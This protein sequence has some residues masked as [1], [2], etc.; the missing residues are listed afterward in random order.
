VNTSQSVFDKN[1]FQQ[2]A[3]DRVQTVFKAEAE[4]EQ[5]IADLNKALKHKVKVREQELREEQLS[6]RSYSKKKLE[7]ERWVEKE[8]REIKK[9][10]RH[11]MQGCM[12]LSSLLDHLVK[13]QGRMKNAVSSM[14]KGNQARQEEEQPKTQL[15]LRKSH[16]FDSELKRHEEYLQE[17]I[18]DDR[19]KQAPSEGFNTDSGRCLSDGSSLGAAKDAV[20][21]QHQSFEIAPLF[22]QAFEYQPRAPQV[23]PEEAK[24]AS[25][26]SNLEDLSHSKENSQGSQQV[27]N[28][29][30]N[31]LSDTPLYR[32][33]ELVGFPDVLESMEKQ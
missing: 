17:Q 16:S 31:L 29:E 14:R 22:S 13:E 4:I 25:D 19:I 11:F 23:L 9:T 21:E 10:K 15:P 18:F 6:V 32:E 1:S 8:K 26:F 5:M 7:L 3:K 30:L 20:V 28:Q 27:K 2:F 33:D 12:R 24:R